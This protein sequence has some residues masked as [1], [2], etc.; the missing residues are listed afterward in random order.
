LTGLFRRSSGRPEAA[1][2][3]PLA[4]KPEVVA[5]S[6][7]FPRFLSALVQQPS[8]VL[9]DLGPAVGANVSFFG[10]RLAC[11][12]Y[13]EDLMA[14][15]EGHAR[16]GERDR[17]PHLL[18]NRL[19]E[20]D[21]SVDGILCWEVFDFL[22]R[23]AGQVLASRLVRVLRRGG[24]LYGFFGTTAVD[25]ASYSRYCVEGDDRLR[26]RPVPATPVRREVLVTRDLIKMFDGLIVT[27]SVLLK[28]STRETLFRKP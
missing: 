26:R 19:T 16:R 22:G 1:A 10:E 12:I 25:L 23:R 27:E 20:A 6:K 13:V 5:T 3:A 14:D 8:P 28:S 11:K 15:I 18:T 17:L 7:V 24:A 21:G 2:P 9:L 4:R